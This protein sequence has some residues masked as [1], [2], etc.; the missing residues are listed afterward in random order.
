MPWRQ[1][2]FFWQMQWFHTG[3]L[4]VQSIRGLQSYPQQSADE[5]QLILV[6][7]ASRNCYHL[8]S[9]WQFIFHISCSAAASS[10][11]RCNWQAQYQAF[12]FL[13]KNLA[14]EIHAIFIYSSKLF[15]K[16]TCF[17]LYFKCLLYI[18][19]FLFK[20]FEVKSKVGFFVFL[21]L[22]TINYILT[23]YVW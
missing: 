19:Y 23:N 14:A 3:A 17:F 4:P 22:I 15:C 6:L 13:F 20:A 18:W 10:T 5:E 2:G 21:N 1:R 16:M 12:F 11:Y 9:S 7:Q 8:W